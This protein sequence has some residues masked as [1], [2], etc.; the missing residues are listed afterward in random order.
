MIAMPLS[1]MLGGTCCTPSALRSSPSTTTILVYEVTIIATKGSTPIANAMTSSGSSS[2]V[3]VCVIACHH[4][5]DAGAQPRTDRHQFRVA[6]HL[7]ARHQ[8]QPRL[9]R[10]RPEF[11]HVAG[12]DRLQLR[13]RH[14][15]GLDLETHRQLELAD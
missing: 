5:C 4:A 15:H 1:T 10:R 12:L 2:P 13:Q 14:R 8:A 11:D 3:V 7:A 6:D 9:G